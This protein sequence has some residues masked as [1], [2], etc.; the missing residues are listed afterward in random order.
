MQD[1]QLP[2]S[3]LNEIRAALLDISVVGGCFCVRFSGWERSSLSLSMIAKGINFRTRVTKTGTGD[4]A[5]F[6][7]RSVFEALGGCREW[8]LFEDVDL[9]GRMKQQGAF[10]VLTPQVVIS[11]RG[12]FRWGLGERRYSS[13][14]SGIGY[15]VGISPF[16]LKGWFEDIRPHMQQL[17]ASANTASAGSQR[18]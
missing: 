9:V 5:I 3:A 18:H 16:K 1:T 15:W 17:S 14:C 8:P 6:I 7:R 10:R 13:I 12:T 11:P 4:Q 2:P